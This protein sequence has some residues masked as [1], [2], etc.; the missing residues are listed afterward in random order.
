MFYII[1][2]S[3]LRFLLLHLKVLFNNPRNK[4]QLRV[5]GQQF[6]PCNIKY[7]VDACQDAIKPKRKADGEVTYGYIVLDFRNESNDLIRLRTSIF[8]SENVPITIYTEIE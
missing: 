5:L 6:N 4:T 8:P 3:C 7:V 2:W 1:I